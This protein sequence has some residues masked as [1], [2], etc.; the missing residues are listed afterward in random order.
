MQR[1]SYILTLFIIAFLCLGAPEHFVTASRA[2]DPA[3]LPQV[4]E[5]VIDSVVSLEV[6]APR[7][8]S[9]LSK[10]KNFPNLPPDHPLAKFFER[11]AKQR[12]GKAFGSS[13]KA[14]GIIVSQDGLIVT[15]NNVIDSARKI[16]V[17]LRSGK[18]FE[19]KIVAG[20]RNTNIALL[21]IS[22]PEELVPAK[23]GDSDKVKLGEAVFAIA[24]HFGLRHTITSGII[25][26]IGREFGLSPYDYFQ[27]DAAINKGSSGGALF[28]FKGEI[29]GMPT[30]IFSPSG[31]NVGVAF[32]IPS[33]TLKRVVEELKTFGRVRRGWL[34]VSIRTVDRNDADR[35]G[36]ADPHGALITTIIEGGPTTKSALKTGDAILSV[37][38]VRVKDSR[39]LARVIADRKPG[40]T[41]DIIVFRDGKKQTIKVKLGEFPSA[42]KPAKL[43][44]Q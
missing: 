13:T 22:S 11:F 37:D 17:T 23:F 27:T 39:H 36:L 32:A 33:N 14:S 40:K 6:T 3:A 44:R 5:R 30:A 9:G 25:S 21:K 42:G 29:I 19:A 8:S 2:Q 18:L 28:N 16:T 24:D 35:I 31:G 4:I 20:D 7:K 10:Q 38:G 12:A 15:A 41:V 34:G 26:A 43:M 1:H